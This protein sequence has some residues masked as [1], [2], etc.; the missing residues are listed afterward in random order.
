M[1]NSPK[2]PKGPVILICVFV[3]SLFAFV[4]IC[5]SLL[6]N[7]VTIQNAK[8]AYNDAIAGIQENDTEAFSKYVEAY[9]EL[10]GLSLKG[11]NERMFEKVQ[12]LASVSEKYEAYESFKKNSNE[13]MALDSLVC[14]AGRCSVNTDNANDAGC[15]EALDAVKTII[16]DTLSSN[17]NMS[18]DEA[19]ELYN[20]GSRN[21]YTL[22]IIEK[23]KELGLYDQK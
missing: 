23:L 15:T 21:D 1:D 20:A 3:A 6:G 14:A 9:S 10:S 8:T 5:T 22:S 19:V 4:M 16:T 7:S 2:L 11:E 12:I 13:D 17:Y 18:Y